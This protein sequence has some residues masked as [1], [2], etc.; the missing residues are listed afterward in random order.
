MSQISEADRMGMLYRF[1]Q[2]RDENRRFRA[3]IDPKQITLE[4]CIK[5]QKNTCNQNK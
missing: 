2:Q 3:T 1:L 4:D 5:K